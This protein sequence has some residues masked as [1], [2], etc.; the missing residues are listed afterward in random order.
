MKS[1][2]INSNK[3]LQNRMTAIVING[4]SGSGKTTIGQYLSKILKYDFIDLDSF[5]KKDKPKIILNGKTVSNWDCIEALDIEKMHETVN[6]KE[7]VVLV[8]FALTKKV[9]SGIKHKIINIH[10]KTGNDDD[11]IYERCIQ[12]RKISKNFNKEKEKMDKLMVKNVTLPFYKKI[13]EEEYFDK[14]VEVFHSNERRKIKEIIEE[15]ILFIHN[16]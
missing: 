16:F 11:T 6:K 14:L 12:A 10:L 5:Y 8:G 15:I 9:I 1:I 4:I 3:Y 7:N 2:K 13:C